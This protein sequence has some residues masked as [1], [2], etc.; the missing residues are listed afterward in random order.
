MW[1]VKSLRFMKRSCVA[2][3]SFTLTMWDV[4][5]N[6]CKICFE[7]GSFYLNYVGCKVLRTASCVPVIFSFTLTMWDV[8]FLVILQAIG[9]VFGFTLTMWDVKS[10]RFMKRS[11]VAPISFTLTMWDVKE[12]LCKICFELGSFYLNYVGCKV[13]RTASCVPVIFSFTLT[14][15]DVKFL[16][17]LQAIGQVFGFTLTMW[18]VKGQLEITGSMNIIVL[19]Y[20]ITPHRDWRRMKEMVK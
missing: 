12:N 19:P 18:D 5:E 1:D 17:I 8:K 6:L 13:L 20:I 16:V 11:C 15:W 4:K 7:L 9:Q 14:M 10:L 3:I 2:P